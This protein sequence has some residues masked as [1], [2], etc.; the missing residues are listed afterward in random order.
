MR[1]DQFFGVDVDQINAI[2]SSTIRSRYYLGPIVY[3][4]DIVVLALKMI[5]SSPSA[6]ELQ[7]VGPRVGPHEV[8]EILLVH[9]SCID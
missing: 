6:V 5:D 3:C 9:L 1:K 7:Q 2:F 8:I 4:V